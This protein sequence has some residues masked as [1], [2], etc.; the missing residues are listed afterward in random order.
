MNESE[1][2][3]RTWKYR[4]MRQVWVLS[5]RLSRWAGKKMLAWSRAA[6]TKDYAEPY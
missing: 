3:R 2:L 5:G 6:Y 4:A 1:R